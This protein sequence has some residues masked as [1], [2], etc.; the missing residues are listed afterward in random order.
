MESFQEEV[1]RGDVEAASFDFRFEREDTELVED[2]LVVLVAALRVVVDP[3]E[4]FCKGRSMRL[5]PVSIR[6]LP[7]SLDAGVLLTVLF[8]IGESLSRRRL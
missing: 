6:L 5:L 3:L 2:V 1:E 8:F 4:P 7:V